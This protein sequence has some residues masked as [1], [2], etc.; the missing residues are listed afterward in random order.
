MVHL[1]GN[2]SRDGKRQKKD[3]MGKKVEEEEEEGGV[4]ESRQPNTH[5][6]PNLSTSAPQKIYQLQ[7]QITDEIL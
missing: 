7:S 1:D 4:G 3:D 6:N 5:P 2:G